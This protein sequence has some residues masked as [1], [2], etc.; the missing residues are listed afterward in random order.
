MGDCD[1]KD[2]TCQKGEDETVVPENASVSELKHVQRQR[3]RRR[4]R[5]AGKRERRMHLGMLASSD[6]IEGN[7]DESDELSASEG[8]MSV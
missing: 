2:F 3:H 4:K 7:H 8:D 6:A 5:M 1:E